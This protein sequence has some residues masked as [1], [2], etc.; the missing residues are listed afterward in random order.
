MTR[1]IFLREIKVT[2]LKGNFSFVSKACFDEID[3]LIPDYDAVMDIYGLEYEAGRVKSNFT[4]DGCV[5]KCD[6]HCIPVEIAH[7]IML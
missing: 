2:G 3:A 4:M 5:E 7:I 1:F 6:W